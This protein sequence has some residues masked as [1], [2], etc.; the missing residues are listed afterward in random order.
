MNFAN[1]TKNGVI[2]PRTLINKIFLVDNL[3]TVY[4]KQSSFQISDLYKI[5]NIK[6]QADWVSWF[7]NED[8]EIKCYGING[9]HFFLLIQN[10]ARFCDRIAFCTRIQFRSC[11]LFILY[12]MK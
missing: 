9:V 1:N 2:F 6:V 5:K 8:I 12:I 11:F 3:L 7:A 10:I 4:L